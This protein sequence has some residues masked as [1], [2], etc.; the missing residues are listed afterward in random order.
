ML[1]LDT[2]APEERRAEILSSV[3]QAI[4]AGGSI[5][6]R[7]DYGARQLVYEIRHRPAADYDLIQ[8]HGSPALLD[9]LNRTLRITDG[10]VR[11]RI[12]RLREGTPPPPATLG[13]GRPPGEAREGGRDGR[14]GGRDGGREGRERERDGAGREAAPTGGA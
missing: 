3:E 1:L 7:H 9:Q 11:F 2:E 4:T 8:F 5:V 14:D 13:A 6:G 10:V 12:I